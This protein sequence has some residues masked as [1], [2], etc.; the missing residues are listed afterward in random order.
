MIQSIKNGY[1]IALLI[2]QK[3]SS[4]ID[5]PLFGISAKTQ[6]GFLKLAKKFNLKI[7]P[8]E[9]ARYDNLNF[10]ITI[11][12]PLNFLNNQNENDEEKIMYKIHK[13]IED[14]IKKQPENWLWHH[15]RW[16]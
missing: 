7:Y 3:D 4:G 6:I 9:N 14:W 12:K 10:K 5:I 8:I 1:S 11:H 16:G 15:K 2:D 13:V